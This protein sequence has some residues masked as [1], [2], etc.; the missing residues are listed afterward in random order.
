MTQ[1]PGGEN[2]SNAVRVRPAAD[3][4]E[5]STRLLERELISHVPLLWLSR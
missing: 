3:T 4:C 1:V 2:V 5:F